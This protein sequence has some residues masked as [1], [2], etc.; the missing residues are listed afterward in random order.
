M[1]LRLRNL[2]KS[3]LGED[4]LL[5]I[6]TKIETHS[7]FI[8]E[9][10]NH[11]HEDIIDFLETLQKY[12]VSVLP[13]IFNGKFIRY[14]EFI[15]LINIMSYLDFNNLID[16]LVKFKQFNHIEL[17]DEEE[18]NN[19]MS[20]NVVHLS[21]DDFK[22]MS[23]NQFIKY[24]KIIDLKMLTNDIRLTLKNIKISRYNYLKSVI[25]NNCIWTFKQK[26]KTI[27]YNKENML[28]YTLSHGSLEMLKLVLQHI[29]IKDNGRALVI[30]TVNKNTDI[31]NMLLDNGAD[32]HYND[33]EA[34]SVAVYSENVNVIKILI[35]R[36]AN[37][38]N[39]SIFTISNNPTLLKILSDNNVDITL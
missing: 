1:L 9:M 34:I 28:K 6:V 36:G 18:Y 21:N 5:D 11:E 23:K 8:K 3:N 39:T 17:S 20:T 33:D 38:K 16:I 29:K 31:L 15:S 27:T 37:I 26:S 30:S 24:N 22:N 14:S 25:Y 19:I 4:E 10:Y 2:F 13:K 35:K 7:N 32:I 12:D